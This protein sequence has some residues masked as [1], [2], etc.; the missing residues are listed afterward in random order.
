MW[1]AFVVLGLVQAPSTTSQIDPCS[2]AM[3]VDLVVDVVD[4]GWLPVP[5]INVVVQKERPRSRALAGTT[6]RCGEVAFVLERSADLTYKLRA[7]G[8]GFR[9]AV[10]EHLRLGTQAP[11]PVAARVQLQLNVQVSAAGR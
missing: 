3:P 1:L 11:T 7:Q 10:R 8:A 4:E 2:T 6:N 9:P 5:G